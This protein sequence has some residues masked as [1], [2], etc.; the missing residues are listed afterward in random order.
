[1][2]RVDQGSN[3][4]YFMVMIKFEE[5][6]GDLARVDLQQASSKPGEWWEMNILE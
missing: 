4:E 3:P 5:G 2:F 6:D 1:M